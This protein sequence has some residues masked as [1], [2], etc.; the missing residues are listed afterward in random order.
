M[1]WA[2]PLHLLG[3]SALGRSN[4]RDGSIEVGTLGLEQIGEL[5]AELDPECVVMGTLWTLHC[6]RE[7]M[8]AV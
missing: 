2:E 5:R 6:I 1:C 3:G 7:A 8:G 4:N